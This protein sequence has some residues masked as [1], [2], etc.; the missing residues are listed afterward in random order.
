MELHCGQEFRLLR[1]PRDQ[2]LYLLLPGAGG[3]SAVQEWI[4]VYID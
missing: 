2:A 3:H 1:Y 4:D